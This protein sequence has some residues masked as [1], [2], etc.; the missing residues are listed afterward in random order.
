MD[1]F[2]PSQ[3]ILYTDGTVTDVTLVKV[4]DNLDPKPGDPPYV[5]TK[6]YEHGTLTKDR[7][8]LIK[9]TFLGEVPTHGIRYTDVNGN[10]KTFVFGLSGYDSSIYI[11]HIEALYEG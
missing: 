4:G 3:F 1:F 10:T 9:V 2:T 6:V 11:S 5:A 7:P 8:L